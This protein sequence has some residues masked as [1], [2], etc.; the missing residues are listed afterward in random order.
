MS[1]IKEPIWEAEPHTLAK[2]QILK[3]YLDAW[4][5][6]MGSIGDR[7][8][9]Y[10]DG[11]A[12][13]G[14]YKNG[15]PGSPIVALR[16]AQEHRK[17]LWKKIEFIFIETREDRYRNLQA[18]VA[19][20]TPSDDFTID[21]KNDAFEDVVIQKLNDPDSRVLKSSPTFVLIDPFGWKGVSF[22]TIVRILSYR[23]CEVLITFMFDQMNQ[24]LS[25]GEQK[26]N[27]DVFFGSNDWAKSIS[28]HG[29]QREESLISAYENNL[30]K[31]ARAKFVLHFRMMNVQNKT[32]YYLVYATN[33]NLGL[34]K[35]K[36]SMWSLAPAGDYQFSD[37]EAYGRQTVFIQPDFALG[38]D[39]I[40]RRFSGKTVSIEE[41]EKFVKEKTAFPSTKY[42][43][44][45]LKELMENADPRL[46]EN[47]EGQQRRGT[48]P[49]RCMITFAD[50]MV[51]Q[52][53]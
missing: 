4:F 23:Y 15:L 12:G 32:D 45:I 35:M 22:K 44:P 6:I 27:F 31:I 46:I 18:E 26:E 48:Y 33:N 20:Q 51:L 17:P 42:R 2:H 49:P 10:I 16:C 41:V 5:P 40:L 39:Q 47:V 24:F 29:K 38:R 25:V 28:L 34:D 21:I 8:V 53:K 19:K 9:C 43:T 50:K 11:F 3:K 7:I 30:R 36:Q 14:Q 37:K 52:R 1:G 13:P